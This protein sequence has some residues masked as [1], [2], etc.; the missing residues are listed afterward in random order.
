MLPL[1][2]L[3]AD[4][5]REARELILHYLLEW[6]AEITVRQCADGTSTLNE[7]RQFQ[8]DILFLDI[9]MPELSGIEI[10]QVRRR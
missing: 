1:K 10:L 5:E 6:Q 4:D 9:M 3:L 8:P 2:V 7:L